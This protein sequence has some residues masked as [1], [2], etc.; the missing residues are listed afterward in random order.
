MKQI[1]FVNETSASELASLT[2]VEDPGFKCER[3]SVNEN[4]FPWGGLQ[5]LRAS[6]PAAF[7]SFSKIGIWAF[8]APV[9]C[10]THYYFV[11]FCMD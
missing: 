3:V 7:G 9:M 11:D 4:F 5:I 2:M 6:Q 1:L 8:E 10:K